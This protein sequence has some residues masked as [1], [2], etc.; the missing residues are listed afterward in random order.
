MASG[1][2][3]LAAAAAAA[4]FDTTGF[5]V[6]LRAISTYAARPSTRMPALRK[7][8]LL[9]CVVVVVVVTRYSSATQSSRGVLER[10]VVTRQRPV[11]DGLPCQSLLPHYTAAAILHSYF[12]SQLSI[13]TAHMS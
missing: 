11:V 10:V 9:G 1:S 3:P 2:H 8:Y 12:S 7:K 6:K 4:F 5:S 13:N